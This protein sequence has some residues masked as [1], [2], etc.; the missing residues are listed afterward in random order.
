MKDILRKQKIKVHFE[1]KDN[2][3]WY[4]EFDEKGR[5]VYCYFPNNSFSENKFDKM[6]SI[7]Y[8]YMFY[9]ID[10]YVRFMNIICK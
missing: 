8:R 7:I 5:E 4:S 10:N 1:N 9:P 2:I 3:L 6:N